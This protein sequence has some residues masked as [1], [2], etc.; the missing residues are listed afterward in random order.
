MFVQAHAQ[1]TTQGF[2]ILFARISHEFIIELTQAITIGTTAITAATAAV[3]TVSGGTTVAIVPLSGSALEI[4]TEATID[5][6]KILL[7]SC[8]LFVL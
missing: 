3:I 4:A 5:I 7:T 1:F 6:T 8:P 2:T